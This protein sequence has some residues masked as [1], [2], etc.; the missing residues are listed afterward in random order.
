MFK[1][2]WEVKC[3]S[4]GSKDPNCDRSSASITCSPTYRDSK[5]AFYT[6]CPN[7]SS[8]KCGLKDA[9]NMEINPQADKKPKTFKMNHLRNHGSEAWKLPAYDVCYYNLKNSPYIFKNGNVFLKFTKI[10]KGVQVYV[11]SGS[12]VR[13][14]TKSVSGSSRRNETATVNKLYQLPMSESFIITTIPSEKSYNT[15]FEF[16]YYSD[17]EAHPPIVRLYNALFVVPENG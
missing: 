10:E 7:I 4:P 11:N 13:N 12:G 15:S 2:P 3:C 14:M 8:N 6:Y 1:D 16:E 9:K 5:F 17:G